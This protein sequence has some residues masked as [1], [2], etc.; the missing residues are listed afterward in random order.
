MTGAQRWRENWLAV[1][2]TGA[3]RVDLDG[4]RVDRR[5]HEQT[6]RDLPAGTPV[7]L[8]AS[9]PGAARRCRTFAARTALTPEREYLAV[10]SAAAPAY[11]IEDAPEPVR[12]FLATVLV[13][14][15]GVPLAG[16]VDLALR[17]TRA[18]SPVRLIRAFAPGRVVVAR[19]P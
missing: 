5:A 2:P 15:P 13:T 18:L 16:A 6:V 14:P 17:L 19:C 9:G 3:V 10:P 4:S 11:L 12:V 8:A 7:V 1:S